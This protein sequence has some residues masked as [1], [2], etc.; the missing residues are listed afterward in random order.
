MLTAIDVYVYDI[1]IKRFSSNDGVCFVFGFLPYV[2]FHVKLLLWLVNA[3][4]GA[5]HDRDINRDI[6][7][8]VNILRVGASTL[9]E[10]DVRPVPVG[11]LCRS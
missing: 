6:K 8:A 11:C 3:R 2:Y 1:T 7:A 9:K 4:C 10:E 5:E